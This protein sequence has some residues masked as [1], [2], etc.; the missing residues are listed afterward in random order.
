MPS[1]L[2]STVSTPGFVVDPAAVVRSS[3]AQIDWA[4]VAA[5]R[6]VSGT[7]KKRLPAGIVVSRLGSG[8]VVPRADTALSGL[9]LSDDG[10]GTV[11]ATLVGH[12]LATGDTVTISGANES[13]FNGTFTITV[14]GDDTFTYAPAT[15]SAGAATGTIV[16]A[17][18]AWGIL[19]TIAEES[20]KTDS[21]SGYGVLR[22]GYFY[23]NI[24]PDATGSPKV[25]PAA[26][27]TELEASGLAY[28]FEQY[29]DTRLS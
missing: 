19:E 22:G 5:S 17:I 12:G 20:S 13:R 11:T 21:M 15:T 4:R 9:A 26:Y 2:T 10:A 14:T 1:T 6:I 28:A 3:G 25:L 7:T 16:G 8:K 18:D 27:K 23:E 24:L 29:Q